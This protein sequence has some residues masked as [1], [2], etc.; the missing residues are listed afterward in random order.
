MEVV[1]LDERHTERYRALMLRAYA[2]APDAFTATPEER[3]AKP[4]SWWSKRL[5]DPDGLSTTLGAFDDTELVGAVTVEFSQR[6]KTRHKGH[7]IGMYVAPHARSLGVGRALLENAIAFVKARSDITVLTLT[8]TQGNEDAI[9][10]YRKLGFA[11]F[12]VEPMA[13]RSDERY[14]AKVHMW[15]RLDAT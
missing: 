15:R 3:A 12:G 1:E 11:E 6:P 7:V 9:A 4:I 10:L 2:D 8:V 5:H 13:I 14:L